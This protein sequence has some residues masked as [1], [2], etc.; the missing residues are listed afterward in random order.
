MQKNP[1]PLMDDTKANQT[2]YGR[3]IMMRVMILLY[4]SS[5][6]EEEEEQQQQA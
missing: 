1:N 6:Q 5:C 2:I 4:K 3:L